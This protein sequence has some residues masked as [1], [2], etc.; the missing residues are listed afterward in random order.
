MI[1]L[2]LRPLQFDLLL[3]LFEDDSE[4]SASSHQHTTSMK[5]PHPGRRGVKTVGFQV[6]GF[7]VVSDCE[8]TF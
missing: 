7:S 4:A 6:G 2:H 1:T 3:K 5:R 8:N